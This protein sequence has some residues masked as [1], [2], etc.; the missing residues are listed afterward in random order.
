MQTMLTI[1]IHV[2]GQFRYCP[3]EHTSRSNATIVSA[4]LKHFIS[5]CA[6]GNILIRLKLI[7][8]ID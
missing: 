4:N 2:T 5:N 7:Q 1:L 3:T 8:K 6:P